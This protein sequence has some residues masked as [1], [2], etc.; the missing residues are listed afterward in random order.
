MKWLFSSMIFA[1]VLTASPSRAA[2]LGLVTGDPRIGSGPGLVEFVDFGDGFGDLVAAFLPVLSASGV[3]AGAWEIGFGIGYELAN[4][5]GT[6][7]GGFDVYDDTGD[8]MLAGDLAAVGTR[9]GVIELLFDGLSGLESSSFGGT[10]LM[11]ITLPDSGDA[12]PFSF[13]RDVPTP[14]VTVVLSSID[15]GPSVVPLPGAFVLLLAGVAALAGMRRRRGRPEV[16]G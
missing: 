3:V 4:P 15:R 5:T 12:D 1:L 10:A 7:V 8:L 16:A 14:A 13:L 11:E 9:G 6:A 2:S